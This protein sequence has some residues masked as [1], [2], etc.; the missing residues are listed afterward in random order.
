MS[1]N[2]KMTSPISPRVIPKIITRL[3][4]ARSSLRNVLALG[5]LAAPVG[6]RPGHLRGRSLEREATRHGARRL[7]PLDPVARHLHEALLASDEGRAGLRGGAGVAPVAPEAPRL[8]VVRH[9][10]VEDLDEL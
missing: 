4:L 9:G 8:D 7:R 2:R 10:H 5:A 3:P 6:A 1:A